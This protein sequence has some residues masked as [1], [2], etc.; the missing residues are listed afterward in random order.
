M[1]ITRAFWKS[2]VGVVRLLKR[3]GATCQSAEV[4][5]GEKFRQ[6]CLSIAG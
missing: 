3:N 6:E 4:L 5:G 2:H 1:P